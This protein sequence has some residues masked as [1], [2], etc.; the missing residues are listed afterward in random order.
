MPNINIIQNL[1]IFIQEI[2]NVV[3]N[4]MAILFGL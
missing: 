2:E 3:C 4:M 1:H